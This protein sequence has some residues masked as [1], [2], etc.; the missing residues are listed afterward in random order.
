MTSSHFCRCTV[1]LMTPCQPLQE[2]ANDNFP[3][4][5]DPNND[6][7]ASGIVRMASDDEINC[8]V[9]FRRLCI[10]VKNSGLSRRKFPEWMATVIF[11]FMEI[12]GVIL[13]PDGKPIAPLGDTAIDDAFQD[14]TFRYLSDVLRFVEKPR[15]QRPHKRLHD[16][17]RMI[18]LALRIGRPA[19]RRHFGR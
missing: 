17:I 16:R 6:P 13:G 3:I 15:K 1:C 5:P 11:E 8:L 7:I 2:P 12:G 19:I 18:D 14:G 4:L 9:Y 10:A